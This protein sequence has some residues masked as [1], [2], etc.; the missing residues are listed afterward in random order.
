MTR[1]VRR[2]LVA[3]TEAG[4][5]PIAQAR[6]FRAA[7]GL[8]ETQLAAVDN[9]ERMLREGS[10]EALTREL[11]D[12]RFDRTVARAIA[13]DPLS[14]DQINLMT[15]RYRE[16]YVKFRSETIARTEALRA[17]NAGSH[18]MIQQAV[19]AGKIDAAQI[20]RQWNTS[21]DGRERASHAAMHLQPRG[22]GEAFTS[23]DGFALMF[24]GD[25]AAPAKETIQCRC[26]V[27][28]RVSGV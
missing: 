28:T 13:G 4:V 12:K 17:V 3:G 2:A 11:R 23:G 18:E 14:E 6:N 5:N 27:T 24:P 21:L 19:E 25:P 1:T 22:F 9:F 10:A 15:R 7:I 8:T 16:R 26:A 20:T